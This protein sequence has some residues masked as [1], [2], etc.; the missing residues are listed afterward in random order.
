MTPTPKQLSVKLLTYPQD[1][2][3]TLYYVWKQS[4][5]DDPLLPPH[6]LSSVLKDPSPQN[7]NR[8]LLNHGVEQPWRDEKCQTWANN[9]REEFDSTIELLLREE[10]P[11]AEN[12]NFVFAIE[13]MP[14]ALREQ[15][16]RHRVGHKFGDRIGADIVPDLTDSTWWSQTMRVLDMGGFFK[17]GNFYIPDSI[18]EWASVPG[19]GTP[20]DVYMRAMKTIEDAYNQLIAA[21]IPKEDARMLIPLGSTH[22][23]TWGCNLKNLMHVVGKRGCWIS[24]AGL[25][26]ELLEGMIGELADKVHPIFRTIVNPPCIKGENTWVGCPI[27]MVNQERIT[28]EDGFPPCPLYLNHY[29]D[30]AV[31]ISMGHAMPT[32]HYVLET[33]W[34]SIDQLQ[35]KQMSKSRDRFGK[36]W[37]RNVDTGEPIK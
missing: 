28:G 12:L 10:V 1:A 16:V 22:R 4:R 9:M 3:E 26:H 14:I 31:Q 5:H 23:I 27:Q 32:W 7:I 29:P 18:A 34:V 13:A 20:Y 33:G 21:G 17:H 6:V 19:P 11:C 2:L 37:Q 36:F 15:M 25:W 35:A 24:Q 30:D 8:H